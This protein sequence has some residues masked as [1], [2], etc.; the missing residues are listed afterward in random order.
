MVQLKFVI[1]ILII[2]LVSGCVNP[3]EPSQKTQPII[4][5]TPI[6]TDEAKI[7][8]LNA[9]QIILND[10]EIKGILG[11]NLTRVEQYIT[12]E[13]NDDEGHVLSGISV[14]YGNHEYYLYENATI[15]LSVSP[16]LDDANKIY[17]SMGLGLQNGTEKIIS[18]KI[19]I[20]DYG[21]LYSVVETKKGT[22]GLSVGESIIIFRKNNII[23]VVMTKPDINIETLFELAKKQDAKI[24]RILEMI[25]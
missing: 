16:D 20:G 10:T 17:Q 25:Q 7:I 9:Q 4:S 24:S 21:E 13:I 19:D 6:P 2:V 14:V 8:N 18:N 11:A 12:P 1:G 22:T 15:G 23:V 5:P 3:N